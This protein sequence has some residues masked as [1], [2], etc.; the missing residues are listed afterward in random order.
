[1]IRAV[2]LNKYKTEIR[3]KVKSIC[4]FNEYYAFNGV[5]IV[6]DDDDVDSIDWLRVARI[7]S[8]C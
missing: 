4:I 7:Q 6:V 3:F 5:V 1:M 2:P 8:F